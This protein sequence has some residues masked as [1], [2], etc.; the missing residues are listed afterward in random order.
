MIQTWELAQKLSV[1][2]LYSHWSAPASSLSH[3]ERSPSED[4]RGWVIEV[5]VLE[6]SCPAL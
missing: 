4:H 5:R 1:L 6:D 2:T 3:T